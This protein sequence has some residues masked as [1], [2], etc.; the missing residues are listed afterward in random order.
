MVVM[1]VDCC[2]GGRRYFSYYSHCKNP[3][4][5]KTP[6][7]GILRGRS[8]LFQPEPVAVKSRSVNT[9]F[10]VQF[11]VQFSGGK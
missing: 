3:M 8:F 9:K 1:F 7:V 2:V 6:T 11:E 4:G 5:Q 10:G